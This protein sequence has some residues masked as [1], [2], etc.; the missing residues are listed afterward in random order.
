MELVVRLPAAEAVLS[1]LG[2]ALLAGELTAIRVVLEDAACARA[3]A[4]S[5]PRLTMTVEKRM[6]GTR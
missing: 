4:A 1:V 2:D 3:V 6:V 5:A